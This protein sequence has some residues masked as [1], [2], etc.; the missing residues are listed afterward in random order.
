MDGEITF[1][2]AARSMSDEKETRANGGV[3]LNPKTLDSKFELTKMDPTL[4][5]QV[6][7]LKDKEVS[8]A[9]LD[10]DQKGTKRYKLLM[11]TNRID[12]HTA[13]YAK[14]TLKSKIWP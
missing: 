3:L 14:I 12:S 5:S 2:D 6:S 8:M 9:I 1:A 13:D 10:E 4:Y 7:N 11:V